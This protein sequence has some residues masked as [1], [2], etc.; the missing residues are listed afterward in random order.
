M[1]W[2]RISSDLRSEHR[3]WRLRF[4]AFQDLRHPRWSLSPT[5]RG[6]IK[7][8]YPVVSPRPQVPR[9]TNGWFGTTGYP[10][11]M[12]SRNLMLNLWMA[13]D[14]F[15]DPNPWVLTTLQ[16]NN[17]RNSNAQEITRTLDDLDVQPSTNEQHL[18]SPWSSWN[19]EAVELISSPHPGLW[20]LPHF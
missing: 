8:G 9:V 18:A 20:C 1:C 2:L 14:R 10:H 3:R 11:L 4:F 7:W 12:S 15:S 19:P 16:W 5:V 17:W 13:R 6:L